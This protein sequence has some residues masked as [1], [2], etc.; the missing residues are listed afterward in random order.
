LILDEPF[1]GMDAVSRSRAI[2]LLNEIASAKQ[3]FIIDHASET[4]SMF[5]RVVRVEK[6]NGISTVSNMI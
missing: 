1:D 2:E 3:I 4:K 6:H 5:S